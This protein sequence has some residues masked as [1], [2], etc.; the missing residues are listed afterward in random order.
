MSLNH[1][2]AK[3][4]FQLSVAQSRSTRQIV[5]S[6]GLRQLAYGLAMMHQ[7]WSTRRTL[8]QLTDR[9]LHDIGITRQTALAEARRLP[10]DL[11]EVHRRG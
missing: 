7:A 1:T 5:S 11:A 9:E 2:K 8:A 6:V 10:W 3:T 4:M